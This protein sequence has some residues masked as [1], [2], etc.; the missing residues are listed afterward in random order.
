M[1]VAGKNTA[2]RAKCF[3]LCI[4]KCPIGVIAV[5]LGTVRLEE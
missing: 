5:E 1:Y 3:I 4:P 2:V